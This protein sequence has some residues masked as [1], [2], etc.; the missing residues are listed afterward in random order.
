MA[1]KS[2]EHT[3]RGLVLCAVGTLRHPVGYGETLGR[4]I[5]FGEYEILH[6]LEYGCGFGVM[7]GVGRLSPECVLVKLYG[8]DRHTAADHCSETSIAEWQSLFPISGG[9]VV[10]ESVSAVKHRWFRGAFGRCGES[11]AVLF[12]AYVAC[13]VGE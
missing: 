1:G 4:H 5:V 7:V 10:P 3:S 2:Y 13:E 8:V 6:L 12:V 11:G 9:T